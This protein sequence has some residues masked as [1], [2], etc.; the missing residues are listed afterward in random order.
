MGSPVALPKPHPCPSLPLG[1]RLPA[2]P[3][4]TIPVALHQLRDAEEYTGTIF[5][6]V[7]L[8]P[9]PQHME[10]P[11]LGVEAELQPLAYTRATAT[12]DLRHIWDLHHSHS[13]TGS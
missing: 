3:S 8:G 2:P 6:F 11:R 4:P 1:T 5:L 7:F 10:V 12:W 13:N 9:H